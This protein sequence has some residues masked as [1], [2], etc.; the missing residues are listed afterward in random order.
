MRMEED[1]VN[2]GAGGS[3]PA[4]NV[5]GEGNTSSQLGTDPPSMDQEDINTVIGE[6]AK[7]AEA[8]ATKIAAEEAAKSAAEEAAKGPAGGPARPL[9]GGGKGSAGEPDKGPAGEPA[10][11]PGKYLKV[12]DDLFV[13]LPGTAGTRAPAEGEVFDDEALATAGLQVVD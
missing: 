10:P 8:E 5:G 7:D 11:A 4:M 3:I 2:S 9:P 12:G 6:V 1:Q 13:H